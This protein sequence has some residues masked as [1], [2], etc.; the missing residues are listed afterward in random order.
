MDLMVAQV[1]H[2]SRR[3]DGFV[4]WGL[5]HKSGPHR[6]GPEG[7]PNGGTGVV[8][9]KERAPAMATQTAQPCHGKEAYLTQ[10][11]SKAL[12]GVLRPAS[13][14]LAQKFSHQRKWQM[15]CS[16][17]IGGEELGRMYLA[18]TTR[19]AVRLGKPCCGVT[20]VQ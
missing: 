9:C 12:G 3:H 11:C 7:G 18:S 5:Q 1:G 4:F 17:H 16:M 20:Y 19:L 13:L 6:S 10:L 14:H 8:S 15:K 2:C